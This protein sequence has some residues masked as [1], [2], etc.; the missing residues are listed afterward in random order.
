LQINAP[1]AETVRLIFQSYV[2]LSSVRDLQAH[3]VAQ[4]VDGKR[5]INKREVEAGGGPLHPGALYYLLRNPVYRG[6]TRHKETHYDAT[7]PAIIDQDLW[8]RAQAKLAA[9][10][11]KRPAGENRGGGATFQGVIFDDRDNPMVA[12]HTTR[13]VKRYRYYVSRPKIT[14]QGEAGSLNRIAAG[15]I[16]P[17]L[18]EQLEAKLST[19]W[20]AGVPDLERVTA[21]IVC[22][23]LGPDMVVIVA[24]AEALVA[25]HGGEVADGM[26]SLRLPIYLRRRL[27]SVLLQTPGEIQPAGRLDRALI[28]ALALAKVWARSLESG[29]IASIKDLAQREGLCAHYTARLLP[30]AYLAPDITEAILAGRQPRALTL[31][32][33]TEL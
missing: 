22:V 4:G 20:N 30:L 17:F 16:E 25:D 9:T 7:H 19:S 28:R 13:G 32:S 3:L 23:T 1:E 10:N 29:E 31:K 33:L 8:D 5:W 27:G 18:I 21:A 2:E 15:I 6:I 11:G 26:V 14:G 24:K 12:V